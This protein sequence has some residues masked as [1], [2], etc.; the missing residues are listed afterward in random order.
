[1]H[2][3]STFTVTVVVSD[4]GG[5]TASRSFEITVN[6][7]NQP[8]VVGPIDRLAVD[9]GQL[10]TTTVTAIDPDIPPLPPDGLT[11]GLSEAPDDASIDPVSGLFSWT[12]GEE[13]GG[14]TIT[15]TVVVTEPGGLAGSASFPITVNEVNEPPVL[16]PLPDLMVDEGQLITTTV[17]ATDP[18]IMI[19]PEVLTFSLDQAP[20]GARIDP[21]SGVFSWTPGEEHGGSTFTVTVVVSD[22][23]GLTASRSFEI[24]VNEVNQPPVLDPIDDITVQLNQ[25]VTFTVSATDGD[26][27]ADTLTLSMEDGPSGASFDPATG[28]FSWKTD[29]IGAFQATFAASDGKATSSMTVNITVEGRRLLLPLIFYGG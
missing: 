7:V 4:K 15:V 25:M 10:I 24:T 6:E 17:T 3:G 8:P 20:A 11:F 1:M 16:D 29:S 5:L 22:K 28:Q 23:G 18:D 27:P 13:H 12:P 14:Q 21:V 2:G 26:I 9:E 19:P